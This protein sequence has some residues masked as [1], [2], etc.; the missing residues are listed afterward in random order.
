[1][2]TQ[3][4][5]MNKDS[6][7][8]TWN[9]FIPSGRGDFEYNLLSKDS[10]PQLNIGFDKRN[11]RCLILELPV[12][13]KKSFQQHEKE[14]LSLKYFEREKCLCVILNDD[15]F[16]D[17]FDDLILS[18]YTRIYT[19]ANA[20]EYSELFVRHFLKWSSFF[21]NK[22]NDGL[23]KEQVK[24]LIGEL[25]YLKNLLLVSEFFIDDLLI[26]WRGPYD[27]DHDFVFDYIDYEVKAIESSKNNVRISSEFQLEVDNGKR[28]ELVVVFLK[29]DFEKGISLKALISDIKNIV[30]DKLGDISIFVKALSQKGLI[31]TDLE[32]YE[33]LRFIPLEMISYD[34]CKEGFPK[35]VR[36]TIP[37]QI[38]KLNYSI[39]L[40]LI[41]DF[42]INKI[43]F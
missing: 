34:I 41:D 33:H 6:I 31:S 7:K 1:M 27:D 24:G 20:D 39:R 4:Y 14:N 23:T 40:N 2:K 9:S 37:E 36:S 10:I 38:N 43:R 12:N 15:F 3:F 32:S 22:K 26:S 5:K 18:I 35:L 30:R 21:D 13:Y 17:L 25:I 29:L 28:L 8:N 19:I 16:I 11:N 42:I